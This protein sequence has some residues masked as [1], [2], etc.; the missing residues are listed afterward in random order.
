MK[1]PQISKKEFTDSLFF[2]FRYAVN[3]NTGATTVVSSLIE[4][5][6][7]LL[8]VN[9]KDMIQKE[10]QENY[11]LFRYQNNKFDKETWLSLLSRLGEIDAKNNSGKES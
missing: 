9:T 10:I 1:V 7:N 5:Y 4:K 3:R 2:A 8:D 11:H 6:W